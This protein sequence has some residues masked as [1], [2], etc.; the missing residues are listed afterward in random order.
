M[1]P[2]SR[3]ALHEARAPR[4]RGRRR[5]GSRARRRSGALR[6]RRP[7]P[8][9]RGR[10]RRSRTTAR[11]R[12][13]RPRGGSA[14]ARRRAAPPSSASPRPGPALIWSGRA[15]PVAASAASNCSGEWVERPTRAPGPASARAS[16]TGMSSWPTW[17]PSAPHAS[18]S[19]GWSFKKK[20]APC[21]SAARRNGS[22]SAIE[23]LG[24]AR[25]LL[26]ELDQVGAAAKRRVEE[27][28]R[29][30]RRRAGPRRRSRGARLKASLREASAS[31]VMALS[32]AGTIELRR[33]PHPRAER[34][35]KAADRMNLNRVMPAQG[36]ESGLA[37]DPAST[38]SRAPRRGGRRRRR[39]RPRRARGE[40]RSA[41]LRVRVLERAEPGSGASGVAAGML[42]PVG[43]ATWGEEALLDAAL[44]SHAMWPEFA[45]ELAEAGE[46]ESSLLRNGAL[47]VALDADEA[48]EL[49]RRF[50]L[51]RSLGLEA[52]WLTGRECRELEPG[53][54]PSAYAG[55]PCAARGRRRSGR[56]RRGASARVRGGGRRDRQRRRGH[57]RRLG[58]RRDPGRRDRRRRRAP[59]RTRR[60]SPR[61]RGPARWPGCPTRRCRRCAP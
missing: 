34:A 23:L 60:C 44:A 30:R 13:P 48:A 29:D 20:S 39:D 11:R 3:Q 53:L 41:G 5:R 18:T 10:C 19:S 50:D 45:A 49:R 31:G 4:P 9:S 40:R 37:G 38:N 35:A 15:S 58:R 6:R 24:A 14:R 57:R 59:A 21:A 25:R 22:A 54:G 56:G 1:I 2:S 26:A 27:R 33:E 8:R 12:R 16:A 43:E 47:H 51:M 61:A 42:A 7:R 17:T 55:R 46:A 28:R 36:K 32:I 52:E